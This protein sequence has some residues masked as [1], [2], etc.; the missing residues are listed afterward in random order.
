MKTFRALALLALFLPSL[1]HAWEKHTALMPWVLSGLTP[2]V[3]QKLAEPLKAPCPAD[4]LKMYGQLA[5][6]LR[7]NP[8]TPVS[9]TARDACSAGATVTAEEL[10]ARNFV[11]D[12]DQG[13]DENLPDSYDPENVRHWMGGKTGPT[14]KGFRHMYFGGWKPWHPLQTFQI[15]F[16]SIGYAPERAELIANK[17]RE[18]L[19]TP[20]QEAWGYRLLAWSMHYLQDLA[21]PFHSVQLPSLRMVPWF[22]LYDWPPGKAF[23]KLVTETT[24]TIS[25]Y[26]WAFE[27]YT[28]GRVIQGNDS[29]YAD[30]LFQA[31]Q[32][33]RFTWDPKTQTPKQ[34]AQAIAR[35]SIGLSGAVGSAEMDFFGSRLKVPGVD[36]PKHQ[37]EPD[38]KEM[39]IRPDLQ[40]ARAELHAATCPALAN[41]VR[42]SRQLIDWALQP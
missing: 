10:L 5:A 13:M 41:A 23:G 18:L 19:H 15:P 20:G 27:D 42:A 4:D 11:D 14:S 2:E 25:N 34:L 17:A 7:L 9:P 38:Y 32:Y 1:A 26:H 3:K 16:E 35:S 8:K 37:G 40:E 21:Q 28:Y 31:A 30:C 12:P 29:P 39:A 24:R 36:L 22:E 33:A 6:E